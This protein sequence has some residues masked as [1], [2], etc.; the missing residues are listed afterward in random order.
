MRTYI[1]AETANTC[2]LLV[3]YLQLAVFLPS[4]RTCS[5]WPFSLVNY[6]HMKQWIKMMGLRKMLLILKEQ[7]HI[8]SWNPLPEAFM[9]GLCVLS[10]S[11]RPIMRSRGPPFSHGCFICKEKFF[12]PLILKY[13][14]DILGMGWEDINLISFWNWKTMTECKEKVSRTAWVAAEI[15]NW[16]RHQQT[17]RCL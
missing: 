1:Y 10:S 7:N 14:L 11:S 8:S 5:S 3:P 16:G 4:P 13:P 2:K 9:L 17:W 15:L 6:L 12:L